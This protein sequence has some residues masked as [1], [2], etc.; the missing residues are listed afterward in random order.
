MKII[1]DNIKIRQIM[2][3]LSNSRAN[4]KLRI[5]LR[6]ENY[7]LEVLDKLIGL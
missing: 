5:E 7:H 3:L 6:T 2:L 4:E 1:T